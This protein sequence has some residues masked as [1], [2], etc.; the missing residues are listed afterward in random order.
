MIND[1]C[2]AV[3]LKWV[4]IQLIGALHRMNREHFLCYLIDVCA[5]IKI[6]F[7]FYRV[8]IIKISKISYQKKIEIANN[9]RQKYSYCFK[10]PKSISSPDRTF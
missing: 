9:K 10:L 8:N 5:K 4:G 6:F 1:G 3:E 2:D 7:N